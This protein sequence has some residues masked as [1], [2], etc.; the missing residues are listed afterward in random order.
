MNEMKKLLCDQFMHMETLLRRHHMQSFAKAGYAMNPLKGQGRVLSLL[1]MQPEISQK[2]LGFLLDMSKQALA[3]LLGK[4]EKS[5]Y[6]TRTQSDKD[7]RSYIIKLTD[8]GR[9]AVP[10][11]TTDTDGEYLMEE[12]WDCLSDD[13]QKVL[14][15]YL[16]RIITAYE[17]L[18][19]HE[20]DDYGEYYR[21]RFFGQFG[22]DEQDQPHLD[23][24]NFNRRSGNS[25]FPYFRGHN[26][27]GYTRKDHGKK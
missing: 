19:G 2:E 27:R 26:L 16:A 12:G 20:A 22:Y 5:G 18:I 17:D 4:L 21:A 11:T 6:I 13:E 14:S 10:D 3:E 23:P 24:K 15:G 7:K 8:S 1:K 25:I 9:N